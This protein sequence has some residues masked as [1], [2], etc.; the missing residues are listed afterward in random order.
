MYLGSLLNMWRHPHTS[1]WDLGQ[2]PGEWGTLSPSQHKEAGGENLFS[3]S[4]RKLLIQP[5][6]FLGAVRTLIQVC[7]SLGSTLCSAQGN[8]NPYLVVATSM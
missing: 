6:R 7:G 5:S 8:F 3:L 1:E 2:P 4:S